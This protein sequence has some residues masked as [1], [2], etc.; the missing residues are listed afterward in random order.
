MSS[1]L[2]QKQYESFPLDEER[3]EEKDGKSTNSISST[4]GVS[5]NLCNKQEDDEGSTDVCDDTIEG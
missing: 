5:K 1:N 3:E 4:C 2:K